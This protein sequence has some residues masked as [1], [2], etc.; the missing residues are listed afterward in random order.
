MGCDE[1]ELKLC[2]TKR[3]IEAGDDVVVTPLSKDLAIHARDGLA[4]LIYDKLFTWLVRRINSS[5]RPINESGKQKVMGILDI[6]G[7]E[8]LTRNR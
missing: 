3:T 2:L 5:I 6:Y 1:T 4:K 8:V 7:F